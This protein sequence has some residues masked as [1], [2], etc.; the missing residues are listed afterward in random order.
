M[1]LSYCLSRYLFTSR[2]PAASGCGEQ[3]SMKQL[4]AVP[5]VNSTTPEWAD[6][7]AVPESLKR[8]FLDAERETID[9]WY[10]G[11]GFNPPVR[12]WVKQ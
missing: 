11:A 3:I 12:I 7:M 9:R 5:P 6:R 2:E 8:E 10:G 4:N 1:W